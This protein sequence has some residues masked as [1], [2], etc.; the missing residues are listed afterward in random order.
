[1]AVLEQTWYHQ[2]ESFLL[3]VRDKFLY[4]QYVDNRI[5]LID[6][7]LT[8]HPAFQCF[9]HDDFYI[10]PVQLEA[11][12]TPGD[13]TCFR[14]GNDYD[15]GQVEIQITYINWFQLSNLS[16]AANIRKYVWPIGR[17]EQ[18]LIQLEDLFRR[19]YE[20]L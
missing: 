4:L 17:R 7:S 18:H 2:H 5:V 16:R 1:M 9:L 3:Q 19:A 14:C 10:P 8:N 15:H 12:N 6:Q 11:V 13:T 20:T